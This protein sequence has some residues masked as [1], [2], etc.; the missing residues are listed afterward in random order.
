MIERNSTSSYM[1]EEIQA[2]ALTLTSIPFQDFDRILTLFSKEHGQIKLI[3][4]G[5]N[6]PKSNRLIFCQ[7]LTHASYVLRKKRGNFYQFVEGKLIDP[8]LELRESYDHLTASF[9][10][11]EGLSKVYMDQHPSPDLFALLKSYLKHMPQSQ[12]P[13]VF[14]SSFYLKVLL[15]EGCLTLKKK[16]SKCNREAD[17]LYFCYKDYF[18]SYCCSIRNLKFTQKEL[19]SLFD[20]VKERSFEK[21]KTQTQPLTLSEKIRTL[22]AQLHEIDL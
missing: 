1:L 9:D 2:E 18:C 13:H 16:C 15:Y 3:I 8:F 6:R 7:P 21:L 19:Q 14:V 4:K 22:Y 12:T 11:T 10:L 5:A 17:S 20:L